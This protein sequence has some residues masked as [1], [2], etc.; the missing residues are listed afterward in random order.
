ME[1]HSD[2]CEY[3]TIQCPKCHSNHYSLLNDNVNCLKAQVEFYKKEEENLKNEIKSLKEKDDKNIKEINQ[4]KQKLSEWEK[5]FIDI[6]NKLIP[7][8]QEKEEKNQE[9]NNSS[10]CIGNAELLKEF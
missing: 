9:D 1:D 8:S 10:F 4:L 6:Y 2:K 5:S 7:N 3:K